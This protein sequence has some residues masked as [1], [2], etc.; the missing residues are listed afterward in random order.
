M[1]VSKHEIEEQIPKLVDRLQ[2]LDVAKVILFGSF[3]Y[4]K[5]SEVSDIDLLVV[6]NSDFYPTTYQEKSDLTLQVARAIRDIRQQVP[7]D[8]IVHT[9]AMHRRFIEMNSL[10]A[11]EILQQGKVIYEANH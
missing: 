1:T 8:L 9:N 2:A 4:G 7:V 10:F 3:A 5:P 11:Q 6:I